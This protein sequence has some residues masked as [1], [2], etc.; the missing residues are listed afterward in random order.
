MKTSAKARERNRGVKA[1]I[2]GTVKAY[3]AEKEKS[4]DKMKTV[5]KVIDKAASK[6]VIH[7]NKA[8]RMKSRLAR[9]ASK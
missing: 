4:A 5:Q 1:V 2:R 7:K 3:R 9:L 6:N 8:S